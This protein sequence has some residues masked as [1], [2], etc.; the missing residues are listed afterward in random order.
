MSSPMNLYEAFRSLKMFEN[1]K[2]QAW[3]P[4]GRGSIR[5]REKDTE[6]ELIFSLKDRNEWCLETKAHYILRMKGR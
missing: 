4:N 3:F 5:L 6:N 1:I 2:V